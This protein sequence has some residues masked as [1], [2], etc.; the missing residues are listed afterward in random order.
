[1]KLMVIGILNTKANCGLGFGSVRG[2]R[3]SW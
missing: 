3:L 2:L 1:M